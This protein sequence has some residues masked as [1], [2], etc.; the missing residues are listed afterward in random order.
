MGRVARAGLRSVPA[1]LSLWLEQPALWALPVPYH[2]Q[3][4]AE[5]RLQ[6]LSCWWFW[7]WVTWRGRPTASAR[8]LSLG[9]VVQK[10][11]ENS[12]E[13]PEYAL[14]GVVRAVGPPGS[15]AKSYPFV[16]NKLG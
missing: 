3:G 2:H 13:Y 1:D 14:A 15:M 16:K 10:K 5:S 7:S 4:A 11:E 6:L 9:A 12:Q 8:G